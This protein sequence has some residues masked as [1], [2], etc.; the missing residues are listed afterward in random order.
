MKT[1]MKDYLKS[2]L[3]PEDYEVMSD[4]IDDIVVKKPDI[5]DTE[6]CSEVKSALEELHTQSKGAYEGM[7]A[8]AKSIKRDN[9]INSVLDEVDEDDF[10]DDSDDFFRDI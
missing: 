9:I 1:K 2:S 3:F 7:I 6:F 10:Y 4:F 8:I 5:S